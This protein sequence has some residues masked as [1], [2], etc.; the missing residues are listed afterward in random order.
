MFPEKLSTK[1][2]CLLI[3]YVHEI[4]LDSTFHKEPEIFIIPTGT[5]DLEKSNLDDIQEKLIDLCDIIRNKFKRCRIIL[6]LL[7]PRNDIHGQKVKNC[8]ELIKNAFHV[9]DNLELLDS[10]TY[11]RQVIKPYMIE[12]I[13]TNKLD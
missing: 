13:C 3:E 1:I 9:V 8:N 10:Q 2:G 7:L 11:L 6:S 5:N 12:S 4:I